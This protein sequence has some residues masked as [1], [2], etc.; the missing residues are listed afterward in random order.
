ML[1]RKLLIVCFLFVPFDLSLSPAQENSTQDAHEIRL[2]T[3]QCGHLDFKNLGVVFVDTGEYDGKPGSLTD[4]CY[5][6]RH[7]KGILLWDTGLPDKLAASKDGMSEPSLGVHMTM[8]VKL[9]DQLQQLHLAPADITY[10][11][12][13]HFHFDHTGNAALFNGSTWL[14]NK[15]ELAYAE[16]I[17]VPGGIDPAIATETKG[18]KLQLIDGDYDVFGDGSVRILKTPG[19][20]PGHQSLEV[21]L[22]HSGVVLLTGDLYN[23]RVSREQRF[24]PP[25]NAGRA[26][27]LASIDRFER[28]A[29]NTHARVIVQH[30]EQDFASLPKFP[31]YLN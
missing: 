24:V 10:I 2:Y 4:S 15:T 28:I 25:I 1:N 29:K 7:P 5:L 19:H 27:T 21:R 18:A 22:Q 11:A 14:V 6:I 26:D 30:D 13:S 17:P 9:A 31:A 23:M 16:R 12:F 8:P 20:T 3:M